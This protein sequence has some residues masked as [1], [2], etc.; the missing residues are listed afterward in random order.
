MRINL[1]KPKERPVPSLKQKALKMGSLIVGVNL[2]L[3]MVTA[4]MGDSSLHPAALLESITSTD[5]VKEAAPALAPNRE[6]ILSDYRDLVSE[7][8]HIPDGLRDRVGF[9]FDVY[10]KYDNNNRIIHHSDFP[11]VIFKVVD[12][13]DIINAEEPRVRWLRNVKADKTVQKELEQFRKALR[14]LSRGK[15]VNTANEYH[16]A[17][18]K[19]LSVLPGGL[20]EN[21]KKALYNVRVQTGQRNFFEEGLEVSPLY[22]KG[23]E[24]IF[25]N[26]NMPVELTRLPFVE[27]SFNKH[28]KSKVGASGLWQF[29]DST[30][31]KFMVV[32]DHIDERTSPFKATEAA[33]RLLKENHM[34]LKRSWP[35]AVTAWNHGPSGIRKAMKR[36]GSEDL[37]QI[38]AKY[39]SGS[40]DFASSNFYS[41]FLAALFAERYHD[42]MFS[43]L[44][45]ER[46]LDLHTVKLA[47]S[48]GAKELLRLS[49][50]SKEDFLLFNPDL[51]RAVDRNASVPRGFTL[52]LDDGSR[53]VLKN[54]LTK[55]TRP[56]KEKVSDADI[57][58]L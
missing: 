39:R 35:L 43:N 48:I 41:E 4:E 21:A 20:K 26:H 50:L 32:Q 53:L 25:R 56:P 19:S 34:I 42:E 27:S 40:F 9:W 45:Y 10:T 23:M 11:W 44:E 3:I 16:V 12:V 58:S 49:G 28:A 1:V 6:L 7:Q 13:T 55:E 30:G 54:L 52:M 47:R 29:M 57:V 51:K 33:A 38:V 8:F 37:S 15:P 36:A 14:E 31:R 2:A 24:E 22:L 46:E 17:I 18:E 5:E